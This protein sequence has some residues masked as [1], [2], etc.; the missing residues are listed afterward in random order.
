MSR[1]SDHP[2]V[3]FPAFRAFYLGNVLVSAA[4]RSVTI[5]L[6]W[7]L[8]SREGEG[9]QRLGLLMMMQ[10]V[11][12]LGFSIF[13]GPLID[14]FDRRRCM[15]FGAGMQGVLATVML[16]FFQQGFSSFPLLCALLFC[17]SIFM[18]LVDDASSAAVEQLVDESR[19][20]AAAAVQSTVFELS[21]ILAAVLST[22]VMAAYGTTAA[23]GVTVALYLAGV[24][25]LA[26]MGSGRSPEKSEGAASHGY[27]DELKIGFRYMVGTRPLAAFVLTYFGVVF[28]LSQTFILIPLI[29]KVV[30]CESVR[31]VGILETSF[32]V[33]MVTTAFLVSWQTRQRHVYRTYALAIAMTGGCMFSAA[34]V[35]SPYLMVV[36]LATL[37]VFF[38]RMWSTSSMLF[39]KVVPEDLKGRFFSVISTAA[40][41][42]TPLSYLTVGV[43]SDALSPRTTMTIDGAGLL[44]LA[45]VAIRLPRLC[46][47]LD[48]EPVQ[49]VKNPD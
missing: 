28:F 32:S 10:S 34:V 47:H 20:T 7:W 42:I 11:P 33:G 6:C 3:K 36:V 41:G 2:L 30:L 48:E 45:L 17:L 4:A 49:A 19:L 31:W 1:F 23:L 25:N 18:P 8:I 16:G 12:I 40:A 46:E 15:L 35:Q 22:T 14:R 39:Q 9:A 43:L 27:L 13:Y 26:M 5:I 44:M 38:A 29:V 37:G 21:N 24:V